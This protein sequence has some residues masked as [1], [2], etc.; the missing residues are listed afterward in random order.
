MI[1]KPGPLA[2]VFR[3]VEDRL[4]DAQTLRWRLEAALISY[5]WMSQRERVLP[6]AFDL[7]RSVHRGRDYHRKRHA[8]DWENNRRTLALCFGVEMAWAIADGG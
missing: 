5:D 1:I 6:A 2:E 7:G 4:Y 8:A 3:R